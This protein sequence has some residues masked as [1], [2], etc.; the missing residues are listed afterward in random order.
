MKSFLFFSI[1]FLGFS[2]F[3][4]TLTVT[5]MCSNG[6]PVANLPVIVRD[7]LSQK[8][9]DVGPTDENGVFQ[10][11]YETYQYTPPF[12]MWFTSSKNSIC[13]S[14]YIYVDPDGDG[15]I[16]LNCYPTEL[17]CSCYDLTSNN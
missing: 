1:G 3:A 13:G 14:Y 8:V 15:W 17:P 5:V 9:P 4:D 12:Y 6:Q 10:I 16:N 2:L 7:S 11:A